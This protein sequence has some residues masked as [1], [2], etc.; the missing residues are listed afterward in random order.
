M[1]AADLHVH[2]DGSIR[3]ETLLELARERG[4]CPTGAE[5]DG[6]LSPLLFTQGMSLSAC[7][8]RFEVTVGLLQDRTTLRRVAVELVHD[9]YMDGVRHL[10]VRFCPHLHTRAGLRPGEA[11]E[12]VICG[13]DLGLAECATSAPGEWLSAG[14][15]VAVLEGMTFEYVFTP[16]ALEGTFNWNPERIMEVAACE[17][18]TVLVNDHLPD[19]DRCGLG[20]VDDRAGI[21]CH[22]AETGALVA[23]VDT[24][25]P[26]AREWAVS[27]FE[28]VRDEATP[29]DPAAFE[30]RSP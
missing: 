19:G 17:N 28:Q 5:R 9:C 2:L 10:E 24:D 30:A 22:D 6:F 15:I 23:V 13:M 7:L 29:V 4:L 16:E 3:G 14:V 11:R 8:D 25:A 18:A 1:L 21:C 12:A 26:E 20:I 27:V